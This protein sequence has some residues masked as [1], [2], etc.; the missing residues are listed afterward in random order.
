MSQIKTKNQN[1]HEPVLLNE[2]LDILD[3]QSGEVY[4]DLTAGYGGHASKILDKTLSGAVLI[5][6]DQNATNELEKLFSGR[7]DVRIVRTDYLQGCKDLAQSSQ[8]FDLILA[9]IG[10]SSPHLDNAS[11]GFSIG[12]EAP[13]DMR[14]D[15]QQSLDAAIVVNTYSRDELVRILSTY[16]E[17]PKARRMA[18]VIIASRPIKSTSELAAVAKKVWPGH[19]RVHPA[20]RLFQAIRIEVNK[21]L[22]QL[23]QALPYMTSLLKPGGRLAVITF[24]SLE[25]RVVKRFFKEHAEDTYDSELIDLTPKPIEATPTELVHNPRARSA[26]MRACK[27]K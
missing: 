20:T 16:G 4:L 24:H 7:A 3:P 15:Q 22:E 1:K 21:E 14:M 9:D 23:E 13:L 8:T 12:H 11:R 27:R 26:K 17:E 5:D 18:D 10:V 19:S 6:R 2:V 25:D